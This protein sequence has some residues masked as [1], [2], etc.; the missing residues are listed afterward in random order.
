VT[1]C[2]LANQWNYYF[3]DVPTD[4]TRLTVT[5]SQMSAPLNLY[6]RGG[7]LPTTTDFDKSALID[8][9]GGQLSI[10]IGDVPPLNAGRYFIG[11]FNPTASTEC[12]V[13]RAAVDR[14]L[15]AVLAQAYGSAGGSLFDDAVTN[16]SLLVTNN[17][18]ITDLQVGLRIAHQR[19]SDLVFHLIS[20][21]GTRVLLAENRGRNNALGYGQDAYAVTP[22]IVTNAGNS[23]PENR[24][25]VDTGTN[26]GSIKIDYDFFAGR[27]D[28]LRIYYDGVRIFDSGLLFGPGTFNLTYGPGISNL[29]TIVMNEGGIIG[30][31]SSNW[32]YVAAFNSETR[33]VY[34]VF[35]EDTNLTSTPIKFGLAPFAGG[36]V[37]TN[38]IFS[39]GFEGAAPGDYCA[40]TNFDG[41]QVVSNM[42][43][44]VSNVSLSHTGT[45]YLSL[46]NGEISLALPTV[47]GRLYQ[48]QHAYRR[49][50]ADTSLV[51]WW[52][53]E[54][55][56][57]DIVSSN[58]GQPFF[59]MPFA[60]SP[61]GSAFD[62]S[63]GASFIGMRV[64]QRANLNVQSFTI[65]AWI[66]PRDLSTSRPVVEYYSDSASKAAVNL[67]INHEPGGAVRLGSLYANIRP[68]G[69]A[70]NQELVTPAFTIQSNVWQHVALTYDQPSGVARIY[71][72]GIM[73]A[74]ANLG[75]FTPATANPIYIGVRPPG[76][77]DGLSTNFWGQ[78]DEVDVFNRALAPAEIRAIFLA[79]FVGKCGASTFPF[80]APVSWWPGERDGGDIADGNN[81]GLVGGVSFPTGMVGRAFNFDG[82]GEVR[83]NDNANLNVQRF[84]I[85][86][87]VFPTSLDGEMKTILYKESDNSALRQYALA[88]KGATNYSC[89]GTI[90][91]GE[92][93]FTIYGTTGSP[94]QNLPVDFCG[95][96]N[97]GGNIPLNQWTHVALTYDG[98][99][100]KTYINGVVSRNYT[101]VT[102][103]VAPFSGP[104]RIGSRS[105]AIVGPFPRERFNGL[106]DETAIYDFALDHC[107]IQ[108]I[109][110]A[111]SKGKYSL[112]G[113]TGVCEVQADVNIEGR[114][115]SIISGRQN[116]QTN[117]VTFRATQNSSPLTIR[118]REPEMWVDTYTLTEITTTGNYF[119]PEETLRS[120]FG[121]S[122][123]GTWR[124]E[125]WDNRVGA[126]INPSPAVLSWELSFIFARTNPPAQ[127]LTNCLPAITNIYSIYDTNCVQ[128]TNKVAG[129]QFKYFYV[130]VPRAARF[131]TNTLSSATGNLV[132]MFNQTG[133]PTGN[134]LN[135]DVIR[136]INPGVGDEVLILQTNG[137]PALMPGQRYYLAVV[138][139][140][141]AETN[142]FTI[143][144]IFD[145]TDASL[146][147]VTALTNG[148]CYRST[149]PVTNA[150]DYYQFT[151]STNAQAVSFAL[152]PVNGDVNL[153]VRKARPV[154]DP[155]PTPNP[156]RFDYISQ[157]PGTL[158]DEITVTPTT[159]PAPL[160]PGVWYIGVFNVDAVP[161]TY[162]LCVNETTNSTFFNIIPL[163]NGVPL[164][165][166]IGT[167]SALTNYFLL[168]VSQTNSAVLFELY[169]LND[170][171]DLLADVDQFPT[172]NSFLSKDFGLPNAPAQIV[173]RTSIFY[174]SINGAWYLGVDNVAN[175]NL[176]FT[177]R[178]VVST[179]GILPSGLP[180]VIGV[181]P[182][183]PPETGL[184]FTWYTVIGEKYVI[185]T[186]TDL[187]NWTLLATITA[188]TKT[189]V[190]NDPDGGSQ[191]M[192]FYRIRQVP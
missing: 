114:L 30:S 74:T 186:S 96:V 105:P 20:P 85:E 23:G 190:F 7:A 178:A 67:W 136:D 144:V 135:G 154:T 148:V 169:N 39:N 100:V 51:S 77:A 171:A 3:L 79:S 150:L 33:T 106:I 115:G 63:S 89:V 81:G 64:P 97:G 29:V 151:V 84:T 141:P 72:N 173:I 143:S 179:N 110:N 54:N 166:T 119:L 107:E 157:N 60:K 112:R 38:L 177:I 50:P 73:V 168:S 69:L 56:L 65:D 82:S 164:D 21:Q 76:S 1:N 127:Q 124:L 34:T 37:G 45:N 153:V 91:T 138:N 149:I 75:T 55:D 94:L 167:G 98:N 27:Q 102:A 6:I 146:I 68:V 32:R 41:W 2:V 121:Q 126:F 174:P 43:T 53:A 183:A 12:Y 40:V 120:L 123:F 57:I 48:L 191:P 14:D 28:D 99:S 16:L 4:G 10:G 145:Q 160:E 165:Y 156:G 155:L 19:A 58:N 182:A 25:T 184:T 128:I 61:I 66:N 70:T 92:L 31:P 101:N 147:S 104:L 125:V 108:A 109:Y 24:L 15:A 113:R 142:D 35:T 36:P 9:P 192:L 189:S 42:V 159:L 180:L 59:F 26:R 122:A 172:R 187:V 8:P 83:V 5:L 11:V 46:M 103:S 158:R 161:V 13:I 129:S 47:S 93:A 139:A 22:V 90:N 95:W 111:G 18:S 17:R 87:W 131:A 80:P 130:D 62:F 181:S 133:L 175:T 117:L 176:S 140:N 134:V 52:P 88:V 188:S 163:T 162:D 132:L 185:E 78:I 137:S 170:G 44:V 71:H 49:S 116:W 118:A 152:N 86:T